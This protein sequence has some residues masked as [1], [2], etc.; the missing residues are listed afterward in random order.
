MN[1]LVR[2]PTPPYA[3]A[4]PMPTAPLPGLAAANRQE[5]KSTLGREG[6][7]GSSPVALRHIFET[8]N[9]TTVHRKDWDSGPAGML[10]FVNGILA[11]L[12]R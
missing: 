11:G 10:P 7:A 2:I 6:R 4:D 8:S 5:S 1:G 9:A 3:D 12:T